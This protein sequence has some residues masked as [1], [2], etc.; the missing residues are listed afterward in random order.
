MS[1]FLQKFDFRL[2]CTLKAHGL[3][4]TVTVKSLPPP[5]RFLVWQVP[6][7][8]RPSYFETLFMR[9][10]LLQNFNLC[11][12]RSKILN[13]RR[14]PNYWRILLVILWRNNPTLRYLLH[15][16][17]DND[18]SGGFK[19]N[20][21]KVFCFCTYSFEVRHVNKIFHMVCMI[22]MFRILR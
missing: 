22:F 5:N 6:G 20:Y 16:D 7:D 11:P 1:R 14:F 15:F 13:I 9:T 3:K 17:T 19:R 12:W 8:F 2:D 18:C 10:M 21:H 4:F